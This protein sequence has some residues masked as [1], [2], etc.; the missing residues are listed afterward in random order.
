M[1]GNT[2]ALA[3]ATIVYAIVVLVLLADIA[4]DVN[5]MRDIANI[6]STAVIGRALVYTMLIQLIIAEHGLSL[7]EQNAFIFA[8][9]IGAVGMARDCRR[10][11]L[12][13]FDPI[14]TSAR[15]DES[16]IGHSDTRAITMMT[17]ASERSP[18]STSPILAGT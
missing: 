9:A 2:L 3:V 16:R 13:M 15:E 11:Q 4:R 8:I 18:V 12:P 1:P 7:L 6:A 5:G 14:P 17:T 10:A